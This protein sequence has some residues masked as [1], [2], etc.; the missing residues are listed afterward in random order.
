M[1]AIRMQIRAIENSNRQGTNSARAN[2]DADENQQTLERLNKRLEE[3]K[4][5]GFVSVEYNI[6]KIAPE[7]TWTFFFIA[8]S[9]TLGIGF[10]F[11]ALSYIHYQNQSNVTLI[12]FGGLMPA[13]FSLRVK[14]W[15]V[16]QSNRLD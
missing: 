9:L 7:D 14:Y 2:Q 11:F 15:M 13:I 1:V 5:K 10:Y 12:I 8:L 4:P 16:Y 3:L 6:L